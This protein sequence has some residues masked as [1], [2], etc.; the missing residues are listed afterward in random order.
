MD[1]NRVC[2][3]APRYFSKCLSEGTSVWMEDGSSKEIQDIKVGDFV[4]G[5]DGK[6]K[7]FKPSQVVAVCSSG[8]KQETIL[9]TRYGKLKCSDEHGIYTDSGW[10]TANQVKAGD[11]IC[12]PSTIEAIEDNELTIP[13]AKLLGYLIGDGSL[14]KGCGFTNFNP[15]V[16]RDFKKTARQLG[17]QVTRRLKGQYGLYAKEKWNRNGN[18]RQ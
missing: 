5:W 15:S 12:T 3:R 6:E 8:L 11:W 18:P 10:K 1:E 16:V 17:F 7:R 4:L 9:S 14:I 2:V 13:E